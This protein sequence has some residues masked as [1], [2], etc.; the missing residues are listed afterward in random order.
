MKA[1]R[2]ETR[3]ERHRTEFSLARGVGP[4]LQLE[5]LDPDEICL[6]NAEFLER[7]RRINADD[8]TKMY[9][10]YISTL[11]NWGVMCPHPQPHRLYDGWHRTDTP[12]PFEESRW[13]NCVL[14]D[15]VVINRS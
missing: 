5:E 3:L 6:V 8:I 7:A 14:C 10:A 2:T 12:V 9:D 15:A 1:S 4:L 13:F 11:H